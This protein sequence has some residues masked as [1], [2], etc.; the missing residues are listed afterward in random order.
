MAQFEV[1]AGASGVLLGAVGT[2]QVLNLVVE[3][4]ECGIN[5]NIVLSQGTGSLISPHVPQWIGR[6][7]SLTQTSEGRHVNARAWGPRRT[8]GSSVS[9]RTLVNTN[10][11]MLKNRK[12]TQNYTNM[13]GNC[14]LFNI[15]VGHFLQSVH[16]VLVVRWG[17][18]VR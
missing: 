12:T 3:R 15:Q 18:V 7:L 10:P 13:R 5:L 9:R 14:V 16:E 11:Q 2:A 6:L 1:P 4:L 17:Q 8:R